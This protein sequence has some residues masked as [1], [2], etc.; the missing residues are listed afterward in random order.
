MKLLYINDFSLPSL[1]DIVLISV[2]YSSSRAVLI[3]SFMALLGWDPWY[4]WSTL[5]LFSAH[6]YISNHRGLWLDF[7]KA[8]LGYDSWGVFHSKEPISVGIIN[9][10]LSV[11]RSSGNWF[12]EFPPCFVLLV[13]NVVHLVLPVAEVLISV[14][15]VHGHVSLILYVSVTRI[16]RLSCLNISGSDTRAA[17]SLPTFCPIK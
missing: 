14:D 5:E 6:N 13:G 10:L 15:H 2:L 4:L 12:I 9:K 8:F 7:F 17:C 3:S 16:V 11:K 1:K